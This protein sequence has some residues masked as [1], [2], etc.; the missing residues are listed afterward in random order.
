MR[1]LKII[2]PKLINAQYCSNFVHVRWKNG[3]I[4]H[5]QITPEMYRSYSQRMHSRLNAIKHRLD[6]LRQ[7][8]R[9]LFGTITEDN[10]SSYCC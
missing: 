8:S 10:V 9:E 5:V 7:G 6:L 3:N 4:V 2:Q 1:I